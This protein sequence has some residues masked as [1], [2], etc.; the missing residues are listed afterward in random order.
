M[1]TQ[2]RKYTFYLGLMQ[3]TVFERYNAAGLSC[4]SPQNMTIFCQYCWSEHYCCVCG[5]A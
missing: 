2:I 3:N 5:K 1:D 4:F